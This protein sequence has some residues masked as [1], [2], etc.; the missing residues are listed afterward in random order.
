MEKNQPAA[1]TEP[2]HTERFNALLGKIL[3]VPKAEIDR[4]K[5]EWNK[6]RAEVRAAKKAAK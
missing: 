4:R 5:A 2:S 3:S 6:Q 1:P